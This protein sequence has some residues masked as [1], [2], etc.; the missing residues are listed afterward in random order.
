[1]CGKSF[2]ISFI[3]WVFAI[4]L[5]ARITTSSYW[6]QTALYCMC[7]TGFEHNIHNEQTTEILRAWVCARSRNTSVTCRYACTSYYGIL[8][9][10][11]VSVC[12]VP[13]RLLKIVWSSNMVEMFHV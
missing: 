5:R 9:C 3:L 13:I 7:N 8:F 11:S 12:P 2:G 1:M 6:S 4:D 10:L